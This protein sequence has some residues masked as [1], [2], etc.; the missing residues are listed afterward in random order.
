MCAVAD[1]CSVFFA[2]DGIMQVIREYLLSITVA[3][4]LCAMI[5]RM[6]GEKGTSASI[7]KLITALFMVI[8]VIAPLKHLLSVDHLDLKQDFNQQAESYVRDGENY[9][10]D[11]IKKGIVERTEA[12]I[13]EKANE[14]G[15]QI[16]VTVY[17]SDDTYPVPQRV[18]IV[19]EVSPLQKRKI[20]DVLEQL[21]IAEEDQEWT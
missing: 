2:R 20:Q 3:G 17:L 6:L 11:L 7:G 13:L 4:V 18:H 1:Q 15:A 10:S 19:G 9:A 16:D 21:G 8:T 14:S 5:K 12:Y